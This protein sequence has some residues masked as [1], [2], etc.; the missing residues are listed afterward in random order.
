MKEEIIYD[1]S[2]FSSGVGIHDY[3]FSLENHVQKVR[4]IDEIQKY[5]G[6][7]YKEIADA[8]GGWKAGFSEVYAGFEDQR[9]SR[10]K[11][12][13]VTRLWNLPFQQGG[14]MYGSTLGHTHPPYPFV[15]QEIYEFLGYGGM[16]ISLKDEMQLWLCRPADKVLVPPDCMMTI[17]NFS[18]HLTTL[19]MANPLE[20]KSDKKILEEKQGPL[21]AFYQDPDKSVRLEFNH[22]YGNS[23]GEDATL[24]YFQPRG[25]EDALYQKIVESSKELE[26]CH[27]NVR[28][29]QPVVEG[30]GRSGK[31]YRLDKPLT[32]LVLSEE[33]PVHKMLGIIPE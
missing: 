13:N 32:E 16:L 29:A 25:G 30:V 31:V 23:A 12:P 22:L 5:G 3:E 8:Q 1:E 6:N 10:G 33:K 18:D 15:V 26:E 4:K 17:L 21:L 9:V 2:G 14:F 7:F 19:D 28:R 27:I 20:N 11:L 24:M